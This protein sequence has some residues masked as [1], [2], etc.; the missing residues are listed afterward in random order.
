M[1]TGNLAGAVVQQPSG[2]PIYAVGLLPP[3][4]DPFQRFFVGDAIQI[5]EASYDGASDSLL[6]IERHPDVRSVTLTSDEFVLLENRAIAAGDTL[7][8]DQDTTSHVI[9]GP[10]EPDQY[11]YDAL[12]PVWPQGHP[13]EGQ[14]S[15]GIL[16]WLVDTSVL[17]FTTSLRVNDDFGFN[18]NR[19]RLGVSVI[20][21]DGLA[22]L[23]DLGSPLLF[24]SYRDPFYASNNAV[25]SDPATPCTSPR[26]ARGSF[27][28]SR[29]MRTSRPAARSCWRWM[30]TAIPQG[31]SK[32]AGRAAT[33]PPG[34]RTGSS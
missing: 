32:C 21:A 14:P 6:D 25:L 28:D 34:P 8:L 22:D 10:K 24:G 29:Q 15:G 19:R 4:I 20:E 18:T 23:G 2:G 30:P 12:L 5:T 33:P 11:E 26:A 13:K 9:L 16:A 17:T 3:S 31:L 1:D 27:R 7:V